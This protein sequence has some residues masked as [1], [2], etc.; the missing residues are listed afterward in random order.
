[1][2]SFQDIRLTLIRILYCIISHKGLLVAQHPADKAQHN[3]ATSTCKALTIH[4]FI[5]IASSV[6]DSHQR[7]QINAVFLSAII[8]SA[9]DI[10]DSTDKT[11]TLF[12]DSCID[13]GTVTSWSRSY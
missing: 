9:R 2:Q 6:Y 8:T 12:T 7:P 13:I 4:W 1:L 10:Y 3:V 5:I 11:R